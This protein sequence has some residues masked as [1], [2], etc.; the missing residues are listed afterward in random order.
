MVQMSQGCGPFWFLVPSFF[1]KNKKK[2]KT[3]RDEN[4]KSKQTQAALA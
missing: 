1:F 2:Q 3:N 4:T